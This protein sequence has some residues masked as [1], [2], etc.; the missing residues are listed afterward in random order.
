MVRVGNGSGLLPH[1]GSYVT[2]V[3]PP[4]AA[5]PQTAP[6]LTVVIEKMSHEGSTSAWAGLPDYQTS[7]ETL[8]L[9]L[10]A[11][12]AGRKLALWKSSV[13]SSVVAPG[14]DSNVV[15]STKTMLLRQDPIFADTSGS[16][17]LS[18]CVDCLFTLTTLLTAG[19]K[20]GFGADFADSTPIPPPTEF[21]LPFHSSFDDVEQATR[22]S[23]VSFRD[24]DD[25]GEQTRDRSNTTFSVGRRNT[26]SAE[27]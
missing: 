8:K 15:P 21:P 18:I 17:T 6:N 25:E 22:T 12:Y 4:A 10:G 19:K 13:P 24:G 26:V 27:I 11:A 3:S 7:N 16:V 5:S 20:G 14:K 2:L 9:H 23:R 1:G